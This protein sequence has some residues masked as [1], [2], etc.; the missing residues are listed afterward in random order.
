[1]PKCAKLRRS[2][3]LEEKKSR[4]DRSW[5]AATYLRNYL[6]GDPF[7]DWLEYH[8]VSYSLRNKTYAQ[9]ADAARPISK[10]STDRSWRLASLSPPNSSPLRRAEFVPFIMKRG[11]K[12]ERKVIASLF[13]EFGPTNARDVGGTLAATK[14]AMNQGVPIICN[15][16]VVSSR[17]E[18]YGVPDLLVRSD[19]LRKIVKRAP[20]RNRAT[21]TRPA[22]GLDGNPS[23]HYR[24]V[25]IKFSC[26]NLRSD[27]VH[28]RNG[29]AMQAYKGQLFAYTQGLSELQGFDSGVA[30]L[31][32]KQCQ[33]TKK[34]VV[35]KG[36]SCFDRFGVADFRLGKLDSGIPG[37]VKQGLDWVNLVRRNGLQ[38]DPLS[39]E[40]RIELYPNMC[41]LLDYPWR[42]LKNAVSGKTHE[43]TSVWMCGP[44]ERMQAH[45]QGV[46][47]WNDPRLSASLLGFKPGFRPH[48][49]SELLAVHRRPGSS[50]VLPRRLKSLFFVEE[51]PLEFFVDFETVNLNALDDGPLFPQVTEAIYIFMIGVGFLQ[52]VPGMQ[53]RASRKKSTWVYRRFVLK[54]LTNEEHSKLGSAFHKYLGE[55]TTRFGVSVEAT[56]LFHWGNAEPSAWKKAF[57]LRGTYNW[58]NLLT[59]FRQ[60]PITISGC[61]S[62][63]LKSVGNALY[64]L[65]HVTSH[66]QKT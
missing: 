5:I 16:F 54:S 63:S 7:L 20:V 6:L 27:G 59:A 52:P 21:E 46:Y 3:L 42:P 44:K 15:G 32:G 33:Y 19:W 14:A 53:T 48:V 61:L 60:E 22:P 50:G 13:S 62:F 17:L 51:S 39:P 38:W 10:R 23:F 36:K 4:K 40:K 8:H 29:G 18:C 65:G 28:L 45:S 1:M 2:T 43:I 31:L 37:K 41:N 56:P 11:L 25:D 34:G 66:W 58:Q 12:F 35:H 24:V 49:G 47:S 64:Q 30:Y 57:P 26:L 55:V 9:V